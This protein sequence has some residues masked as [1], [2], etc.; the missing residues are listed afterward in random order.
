[1]NKGKEPCIRWIRVSH[2][3]QDENHSKPAQLK[4][5]EEY[6]QQNNLKVWKTYEVTETASK[7]KN[8]HEFVEMMNAARDHGIKHIVCDK[9][10]RAARG[11]WAAYEL[12]QFME[13]FGGT[14]HV[15]RERFRFN[16]D[17]APNEKFLFGISILNGKFQIDNMRMELA[18][19]FSQRFHE[20]GKWNHIAPI[21]YQHIRI[22]KKSDLHL[23][24]KEAPYIKEAFMMYKT[25]NYSQAD[26][27]KFLKSKITHRKVTKT[28]VESL[29]KNQF[30][31][32]LMRTSYGERMGVHTPIISK[33]DFDDIQRIRGRRAVGH[34]PGKNAKIAKPLMGLIKCGECGS[35]ITGE[36]K[37]KKS[38]RQYVYYH[39][40]NQ[41][42]VERRKNSRQEIIFEQIIDAFAPF[43]KFT[44]KGTATLV[45]KFRKST[46]DPTLYAEQK[47]SELAK[48]KLEAQS[49]LER[50]EKLYADG[51]IEK[52]EYEEIMR[53]KKRTFAAIGSQIDDIGDTTEQVQAE[54][55]KVI[56]L[57][58]KANKFM[59]LSTN[60]LDKARLARVVLSNPVLK[61]RTLCFSY[62]KPFDNLLK[63]TVDKNWW[64][65]G[66]SNS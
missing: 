11:Y 9:V 3:K 30:Y 23:N 53:E 43:S 42:C 63:I 24:E 21:G 54:S 15:S 52:W 33:A 5:T 18:K 61:D 39:C 27:L 36:V 45:E 60:E 51:L 65:L 13:E 7:E 50:I 6:C 4:S 32:G 57:F 56:E 41:S 62:A 44:P 35:R 34:E 12:T 59:H 8:R 22:G 40:A 1:M 58:S 49:K 2:A 55:L 37:T 25:G 17:S 46:K 16:S 64:T 47:L 66:E 29:L 48:Q 20:G 14:L 31:Y 38:G 19:G 10:D 28:M 26:I